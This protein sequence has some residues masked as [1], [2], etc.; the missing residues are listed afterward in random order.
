MDSNGLLSQDPWQILLI[1]KSKTSARKWIFSVYYGGCQCFQL[2]RITVRS[3][4]W[5]CESGR[6]HSENGYFTTPGLLLTS[7]S[8]WTFKLLRSACK[9]WIST[10]SF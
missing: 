10:V 1:S 8:I 5:C 6:D 7:A 4:S 9:G 3:S 2:I